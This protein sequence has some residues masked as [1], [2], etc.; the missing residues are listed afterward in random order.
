MNPA[1]GFDAVHDGHT[2]VEDDEVGAQFHGFVDSLLT[3]FGFP[4]DFPVRR[5]IEQ[6]SDA[7]TNHL[8]VV[9]QE[10]FE[11][12]MA[13]SRVNTPI[14]TLSAN[15]PRRY[16]FFAVFCLGGHRP[17]SANQG[18]FEGETQSCVSRDEKVKLS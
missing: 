5:A 14:G 1:S 17:V 13:P 6:I 18:Q 4:A 10:N 3:V 16:T 9:D 15:E 12:Q 8:V 2:H 7:A 11:R